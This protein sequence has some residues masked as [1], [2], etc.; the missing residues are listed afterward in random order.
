MKLD[1]IV[2][3]QMLPDEPSEQVWTFHQHSD[4]HN[5]DVLVIKKSQF[6]V[7]IKEKQRKG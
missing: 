3:R 2:N 7:R 6:S 1:G 5:N 4:G